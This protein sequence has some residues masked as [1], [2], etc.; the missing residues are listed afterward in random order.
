M[1]KLLYF[2]ESQSKSGIIK[3]LNSA[4]PPKPA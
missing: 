1:I 4:S 2:A 3:T